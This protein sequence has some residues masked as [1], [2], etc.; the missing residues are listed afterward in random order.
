MGLGRR[1]H[2]EVCGEKPGETPEKVGCVV[3]LCSGPW[4]AAE[5]RPIGAG[6]HLRTPT[7][8]CLKAITLEIFNVSSFIW[9]CA[10]HWQGVLI[11]SVDVLSA[12][13]GI[14]SNQIEPLLNTAYLSQMIS[15][16]YLLFVLN[17]F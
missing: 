7:Y 15:D 13:M 17:V 16:F 10:R 11:I 5:P 6:S 9:W 2:R 8:L 1:L 3:R 4:L 12:L 14:F